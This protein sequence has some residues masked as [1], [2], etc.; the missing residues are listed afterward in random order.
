MNTT[1]S[2]KTTQTQQLTTAWTDAST[3]RLAI[4]AQDFALEMVN[5]KFFVQVTY[6]W[7][8]K[9]SMQNLGILNH[10]YHSVLLIA[11]SLLLMV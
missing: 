8:N 9:I 2:L 1:W 7:Y 5:W 6:T 10:F 4:Q 3:A 11:N